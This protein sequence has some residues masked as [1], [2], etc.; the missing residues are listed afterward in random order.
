METLDRDEENDLLDGVKQ[1]VDMVDDDGDD[2]DD[3]LFK[4]ASARRYGPG[5]IRLLGC[6]YNTGRQTA[7][8]EAGGSALDKLASFPLADPDRVIA[9]LYGPVKAAQDR[10]GDYRSPPDWL[11]A[12]RAAVKA[13]RDYALPC[14]MPAPYAPD[15]VE[16][17]NRAYREISREKLACDQ[18]AQ[19]A[20]D[21]EDR[22]RVKVASLVAYFRDRFP[23]DRLAFPP[24]E[25]AASA[26]FGHEATALMGLVHHQ[27]RLEAKFGERRA[28]D[29]HFVLS[30][31]VDLEA[32]PFSTIRECLKLARDVKA[33][34]AAA[35]LATEKL[36]EV[37]H[38]RLRPFSPASGAPDRVPGAPLDLAGLDK[39]AGIFATP[40]IGAAMGTM[41]SRGIGNVPETKDDLVEDA[42]LKLEDP[43]HQ[44]E[45]RKIQAHAMLNGFMTDP[46]SAI[47]GYDPDQVLQEYNNLA[48]LAPRAATQPA[49]M[50]PL[51][52]RRLS[53][54]FE[55]FEAK[56]VTEIEK[57]LAGS[58]QPTKNTGVLGNAP[59]K[60]QG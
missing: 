40:A 28:D 10:H 13:A 57:S 11:P 44:N 29:R 2:P 12:D 60:L 49:V 53:G 59:S 41:I 42:W 50:E 16:A 37:R 7:Q 23:Q 31:G 54:Q 14:E 1:A 48:K 5:K 58:R 19:R 56:E 34:R 6:A 43:E 20:A 26:Y 39:A 4:V 21:A 9:R 8:R 52:R 36:A 25:K 47:S 45:L 30:R 38:A 17:L 18:K 33:L 15:P 22:L 35:S 3:A 27:G 32:P 55:P 51:L 24:V 46:D